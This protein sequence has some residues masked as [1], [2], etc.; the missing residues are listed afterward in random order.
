M[1][2]VTTII[3]HTRQEPPMSTMSTSHL[4]LSFDRKVRAGLFRGVGRRL[5]PWAREEVLQEALCRTWVAFV[6]YAEQGKVLT[7]PQLVRLYNWKVIDKRH[8][9]FAAKVAMPKYDV[10]DDRNAE[11]FTFTP[12]EGPDE[13]EESQHIRLRTEPTVAMDL[14]DHLDECVDIKKWLASLTVEERRLVR[15][16]AEGR[17]TAEIAARTGKASWAVTERL[18]AL[19]DELLVWVNEV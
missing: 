15:L 17:T 4:R 19:G 18:E 1:M 12:I 10:M 8:R 3:E 13:T 9:R 7:D 16:R 11:R 14:T 2:N 6:H 5:P